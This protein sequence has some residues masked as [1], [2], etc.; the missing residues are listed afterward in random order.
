MGFRW[1]TRRIAADHRVHG[2]VRNQP[3]GS[4]DA[5]VE[6]EPMSIEAFLSDIRQAM[7]G[8][9]EDESQ[10]TRTPEGLQGF[11]NTSVDLQPEEP[12]FPSWRPLSGPV[13][14]EVRFGR[15]RPRLSK[16][17]LPA[18]HR[19]FNTRHRRGRA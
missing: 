7:L 15:P 2:W 18:M 5:C 3:D 9:I 6:G 10:Q 13:G 8:K 17:S 12:R 11:R 14:D 4:V 19:R 1:T 16:L